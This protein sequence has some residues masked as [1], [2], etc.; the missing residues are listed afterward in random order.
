[1]S[2]NAPR[3]RRPVRAGAGSAGDLR[4]SSVCGLLRVGFPGEHLLG[5]ALRQGEVSVG[6]ELPAL[7]HGPQRGT[8]QRGTWR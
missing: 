1:M 4:A 7:L 2:V 5:R 6:Q 8:W 3:H